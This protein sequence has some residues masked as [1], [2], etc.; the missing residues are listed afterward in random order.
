MAGE[1]RREHALAALRG[2]Q[3]L[4]PGDESLGLAGDLLGI[5]D[6]GLDPGAGV[7]LVV[8]SALERVLLVMDLDLEALAGARLLGD[9]S[10]RFERARLLRDLER[11]GVALARQRLGPLLADESL[12]L[13]RQPVLLGD[14]RLLARQQVLRGGEV[15]RARA[16]ANW[17]ADFASAS[18]SSAS[19]SDRPRSRRSISTSRICVCIV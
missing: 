10:E 18:M 15:A 9:R 13:R 11:G 12:E 19:M 17:A 1:G 3:L 6:V 14:M 16:S 7:R 8:T 2:G 5:D 4:T